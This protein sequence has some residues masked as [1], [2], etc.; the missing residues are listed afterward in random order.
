MKEKGMESKEGS[1]E[2]KKEGQK[3]KEEA[4]RDGGYLLGCIIGTFSHDRM[5]GR[6]ILF[7]GD[8]KRPPFHGI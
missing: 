8:T 5:E 3:R 2:K 1:K 7:H 4:G 6:G